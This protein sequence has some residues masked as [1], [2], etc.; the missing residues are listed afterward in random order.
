M[1]GHD[2]T[3]EE[4]PYQVSVHAGGTHI[5]GGSL[6]SARHVLTRRKEFKQNTFT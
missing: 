2:A 1:G 6:I 5:C 3:I 4:Y